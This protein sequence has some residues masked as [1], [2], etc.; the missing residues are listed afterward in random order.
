VSD[1]IC[2]VIADFVY[3]GLTCGHAFAVTFWGNKPLSTI[4]DTATRFRAECLKRAKLTW[5]FAAVPAQAAINLSQISYPS[6]PS[7]LEGVMIEPGFREFS[8]S[9]P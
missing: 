2:L 6:D 7:M 3:T 5:M 8:S 1:L 9:F 4:V